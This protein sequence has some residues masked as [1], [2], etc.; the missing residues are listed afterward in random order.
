LPNADILSTPAARN[1]LIADVVN[2][3]S[4]GKNNPNSIINV[5]E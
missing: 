4:E 1:A 3:D 2:V 5:I